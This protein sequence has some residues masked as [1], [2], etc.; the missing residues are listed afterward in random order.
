MRRKTKWTL[1][2]LLSLVLLVGLMLGM[3]A[4]AYAAGASFDGLPNG[5]TMTASELKTAILDAASAGNA[6]DGNGVTVDFSSTEGLPGHY[7]NTGEP[8]RQVYL[9]GDQN[10]ALEQPIT[11]KNVIFTFD[12]AA[13][14]VS[15]ITI[16]QIYPY[17]K[18]NLTFENCEFDHVGVEVDAVHADGLSAVFKNCTFKNIPNNYA[19]KHVNSKNIT[20]EGCLI[21]NCG[22]GLLFNSGNKINADETA[23]TV[24]VQNNTFKNVSVTGT[25]YA[26]KDRGVIQLSAKFNP[27]DATTISII[28]NTFDGVGSVMRYLSTKGTFQDILFEGNTGITTLNYD[29][30][31]TLYSYQKNNVEYLTNKNYV[32]KLE[33]TGAE[34][35]YFDSLKDA[36]N[37]AQS[38]DTITLLQNVDL[39]TGATN[40]LVIPAT[41]DLTL[42]LNGFV[43]SGS[44]NGV[45]MINNYGKLVIKDS[46]TA[47]TGEIKN[48]STG[49]NDCTRTL[50]NGTDTNHTASMTIES[51]KISSTVG[52]VIINQANLKLEK[53][54]VLVTTA[55]YSGDYSNGAVVLDNRGPGVAEI[56]GATLT[57]NDGMLM[58]I[59]ANSDTTIKGGTFTAKETRGLIGG[60][61]AGDVKITG[62]TF[63]IDP[64]AMVAQGYCVEEANNLYTVKKVEESTDFTVSSEEELSQALS[65]ASLS[66]PVQITVS[67]DISVKGN[68]KLL[69][70]SSITVPQGNSLSVA[71]GGVLML[72][73]AVEN[74]GTL[75][76]AKDG[77]LG[78]PLSV[79]GDGDFTYEGY[80][81]TALPYYSI[82]SPMGLQW[83]AVVNNS[84]TIDEL[85]VEV[86]QDIVFPNG[87]VFQQIP[88]F[89]GTFDGMNHTISGLAI[90]AISSYTGVFT[91]MSYATF[92][93]VTLDET[94]TANNGTV[95]GVAGYVGENTHFQNVKTAGS[96]TVGGSG[97]G[98]AG[99]V[100]AV[101]GTDASKSITFENCESSMTISA[102][103]ASIVGGFYGTASSNKTPIDVMDCTYSGN[104]T[105][106]GYCAT[107]GGYMSNYA[108]GKTTVYGHTI[109]GTVT[110]VSTLGTFIDGVMVLGADGHGEIKDQGAASVGDTIYSDIS[111]AVAAAVAQ[112]KPLSLN[113]NINTAEN[114]VL[115]NE[116]D[117]FM[118]QQN[119]F[120]ENFNVTYTG[121]NP[122]NTILTRVETNIKVYYVGP[123][124]SKPATVTA[125]DRTYDGTEKPLVTVDDSTLVGG[126][127][128]YA[129]GT[130]DQTAPTGG[131]GIDIPTG[132]DAKTYYVWYKAVGDANHS[133]SAP[134][135]LPVTIHL[136]EP[137]ITG[138]D[139]VLNA[140][141]DFRFYVALPTDFDSTGAHMVFTIRDRNY[142]IPFDDAK[143][144]ADTAT[145]GQ[146]IFS[147]PVYSIEMAV[148]VEAVFHYT[149]GGE[150]K[151]TTRTAS[152]KDYLD[153]LDA[154]GGQ[155]AQLS[156]LIAAVRN[157]GHYIQPYLARLHD[158][159]VGAGGYAEMP[160]ATA[161]LEPATAQELEP[162]KTVWTECDRNLLESVTYYDTFD[163][164]TFLNVQV[165]LK[166]A[167]TLTATVGGAAVKVT[168]LG[169]NVYAVRTPGI[170]A[171]SLGTPAKVVFY[172]GSTVICDI[173]VS[174]L[175]YVRAVLASRNK[176][177]EKA[178]LTAFYNYYVAAEAYGSN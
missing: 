146:K 17:I 142:D 170:A 123:N 25:D 178:A 127:M 71:D 92:K 70:G 113:T 139:L 143:T 51:G 41:A 34:T 4:T 73:G 128:Q 116:D 166:S 66:K 176:A 89:C 16:A 167:R 83:L 136:A 86:T 98:A 106:G 38:G 111:E 135:C 31:V 6:Y 171:N 21:E 84:D 81:E 69:K 118:L 65:N 2:I 131:W 77:F 150:D 40:L 62:G 59:S 110:G 94:V 79:K 10:S 174:A 105:S 49:T 60:S 122:K 95:G 134:V 19:I 80:D 161:S 119:G 120:T 68:L 32:A 24:L 29:G 36:V 67:G 8:A 125:N 163:T 97:Y 74:Q 52:Q 147:C 63:N 82:S 152:I 154:Q 44:T 108:S 45:R 14:N 172:A 26:S 107:V 130:D 115:T 100:G 85:E 58:Y 72:E 101:A 55:T 112:K 3:S 30:A 33:R 132:K 124:E 133:D 160:A 114:V 20:V 48:I 15:G 164:S 87:V 53:D 43:I 47:K 88:D 22:S 169:G 109:K 177:D 27:T 54:A 90:N 64:S 158:F 156:R 148:P 155:S 5:D 12:A 153:A 159:T 137:V 7:D 157:Y 175:T 75:T 173:D 102:P 11:I 13:A 9:L 28:N 151:T 145:Q 121:T 144:S 96:I 61:G 42:D 165:K 149:K 18:G 78:N 35:Q 103:N 117:V 162:Y 91:G 168:E 138:A 1:G 93:N 37:A 76:I 104:M 23:G 46:S 39:G 140:S 126:T 141:L 56:D 57:S 99:F 129:L 50:G